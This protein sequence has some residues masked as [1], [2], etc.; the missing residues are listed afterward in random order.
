MPRKPRSTPP[1]EAKPSNLL[2]AIRFCGMASSDKGPIN[3]THLYLGGHWAAAS[4]GALTIATKIQEDIFACPNTKLMTEA[5]IK[6]RE[7]FAITQ[8]EKQLSIKAGKFSAK[9]PCI[10]PTLLTI[11]SPDAPTID[12]DDK[13]KIAIDIV[14]VLANENAQEII[15]ASLLFNGRSVVA[16]DRTVIFECWHGIDLPTGLTLPKSVVQPLAKAG[17]KLTKLGGSQ[18]SLTFYYEDESWI[19]TQLFSQ[20]WPNITGLLDRSS[21]PMPFPRDFWDGLAAVAPFSPDG[22]CHF[23]AG[24]MRSHELTNAGASYEVEGLPK[25]PVFSI[26][27]LNLIKPYAKTIDF[28]ADGPASKLTVFFGDNIRGAIAGRS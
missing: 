26:R 2:E 11:P 23:G 1:K 8:L 15:P 16:S 10:D 22:L 28:F 17:K 6:C 5:L 14:G 3:E 25:G 18:S 4:N 27:Q 20:Q 9:I 13:L 19:K 7:N 12:I 21:N 24:M